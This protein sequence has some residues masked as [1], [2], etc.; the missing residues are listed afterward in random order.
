[1]KKYLDGFYYSLPVQ[2]F[3]LHFRRYQVLLIF[4][5]ILFSTVSGGFMKSYG[6]N[7]LFLA[8]EYLGNVNALSTAIVGGTVAVF[9]MSWNITTFILFTRHIRFLATTAQPFLKYCINNFI[10]PLIFLVFY[11]AKAIEYDRFQQ[12][13]N[14]QQILW[15]GL[16]F[17]AGFLL[18]ITLSF[19][20]FYGADK[21]I[22]KSLGPFITKANK[23]YEQ[24]MQK[25]K[26]ETKPERLEVRIDW[27]LSARLDFRKP[28]DI[29]H[30]SEDFL[31]SIFK[32]HHIAAVLAI[33]VAYLFLIAIGYL[34]ETPAFVFPAAASVT[35]FFAILIA[36]AG[37]F[38]LFLK[39]WSLV[40][41]FLFIFA[42]DFLFQKQ[43]I[44]FRNKAYGLNYS[45]S[46]TW[47]AYDQQSIFNLANRDSIALDKTNML[48]VLNNWKEQQGEEKPV[49]YIVN[50]SG[51]GLRSASFA[52]NIL[53]HLDSVTQGDFFKKTFLIS[54]ASGGMIGASYFRELYAQKQ[55]G[56]DINIH[57]DAY[58]EN[59][60]KDLLNPLFSSLITRDLIGPLKEFDYNGLKYNKDRGYA[61]EQQLNNNT[62]GLMNKKVSDYYIAETEGRLPLIVLNGVITR[63]T[64]KII[65]GSRPMRYL[66]H[67]I[68]SSDTPYD[69]DAVDFNSYFRKQGSQNI[70]FLSALRINATFPFVLPTVWLPTNPVIDVMDAGLRDNFGPETSLRFIHV[71]KDWLKAN[72][73]KVVLVQI[74]DTQITDWVKPEPP[75]L[76]GLVTKPFTLLQ[77]NWYNLQNYY[78]YDHV[79]YVGSEIGSNFIYLPFQY[80]PA[81]KDAAA[82]LSF[83]LTASEKKD[84]RGALNDS[85]NVQLFKRVIALTKKDSTLLNKLEAIR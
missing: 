47:P 70:S 13:L 54:G 68:D 84:I 7:S 35:V 4:W 39:N 63:D 62:A 53:Q 72:T 65:I 28:R 48:T 25:R 41:L 61:F 85:F 5:Y 23:R 30:Y 17:T 38:S 52:M 11:I 2:L 79:K 59:I 40:V 73:S 81:K 60:T 46:E 37:A 1:M 43:F 44:D 22:Y 21:T 67:G 55:S 51:G 78:M 24:I 49:M 82:S 42:I 58:V 27:F 9:I 15:L 75:S 10:L 6:A 36:I 3:L 29:R 45:S 80:L 16:G 34:F 76:F 77:N 18:M 69:I 33:I 26:K 71:F 31:D 66:M 64:R 56:S 12:L 50:V 74:R 32:R 83:H 14:T 20:Y 19:A 57:D 8:P